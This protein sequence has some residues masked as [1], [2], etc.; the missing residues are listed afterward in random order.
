[1]TE[2][3]GGS[4]AGFLRAYLAYVFLYDFVFAY[5]IYT[6]YFELRGLS[7]LEIGAL[8][9]IWS[10]SALAF[11]LVT[12][13]LS[14]WLD[15]RLLLIAAPFIKVLTF[16]AWVLADG[17]FWLYALGF[18]IWSFSGA[19][20]SGTSEALLFER[21]EAAG[22]KDDYDRLFG[23]ARASQQFGVGAS[24]VL[25]G[26]IA[27]ADMDLTFVLSMP[28]MGL[29]ALSALW[30][31]DVRRAGSTG[32]TRTPGFLEA[33]RLAWHD[34]GKAPDARFLVA[35]IAVG[36]ILFEELEEFDQLFYVAVDLPVAVFGIAGVISLVAHGIGAM[37]AHRLAHLHFLAWGAPAA[38][39]LLLV[40]STLWQTPH[41]V[42]VLALAYLVAVPPAVLAEARFQ[43]VIAGAARATA[44]SAL[45]FAQNGMALLIAFGFGALANVIGIRPAYALAGL[46]LVP[47]AIWVLIVQRR[48]QRVF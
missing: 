4:F 35:Y 38:A 29:A 37:S 48:G 46:S 1:M 8:L 14:D 39:G 16:V 12:G 45:Y 15:R 22:R 19:L 5:A 42:I 23:R 3:T 32:N 41:M 34:L 7:Y 27:A 13:A 33:F 36:L 2:Q 31:K 20:V 44:T 11:E 17:N 40:V 21:A 26:L 10:V 25:G 43:Q 30:L 28:A 47:V 9:A 18:V 6:A 24:L